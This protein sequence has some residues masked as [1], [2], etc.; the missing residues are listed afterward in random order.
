MKQEQVNKIVKILNK[1]YGDV[2][3]ALPMCL[4]LWWQQY[5]PHNVPT[6]E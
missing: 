4:N 6:K 5:F 3:I 2:D 1:E